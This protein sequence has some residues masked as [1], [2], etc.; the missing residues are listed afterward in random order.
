MRAR[1]KKAAG[2]FKTTTA[3]ASHNATDFIADCARPASARASF[4]LNPRAG[5]HDTEAKRFATLRARFA[6]H[7]HIL[8]QSGP[9]DGL[10][11][12]T[13]MAERWGMARHLPTLDDADRF[14]VQV[15]GGPGH[16]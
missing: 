2:S 14:L 6:K 12:V 3:T 5:T 4:G 11:P 1:I 9:G 8:H 10:G 16:E 13:Y 7:G 15:S